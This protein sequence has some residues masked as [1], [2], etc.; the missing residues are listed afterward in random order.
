LSISSKKV[1]I[2]LGAGGHA[3]VVA[4][5]L[6]QSGKTILGLVAPDKKK[7]SKCFGLDVLGNDDEL[8]SYS[9]REVVLAN[10]IGA[11]PGI[12]LRWKLAGQ[13]REKGFQFTRVIHP[14]ATIA[15]DV[16]VGEGA[17]VMAGSIIQPGSSIA[18]DSIVNT[19]VSIDH[20][21]KIG[22]NCHLAPGVIL[23]GC[24]N[25]GKGAHLGTGAT[26]IQ[27]ISIGA[28]S[29]VSAG[30]IVYKDL[31]NDKMLIQIKQNIYK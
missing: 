6:I 13:M 19:R 22:E 2:L 17:Q 11:L 21:C 20:D 26:V 3:K 8:L 29:T 25:I 15:A 14:S 16:I 9:P 23:S 24:V 1:V 30:S 31:V 7:G 18:Q 10:G 4:E 28:N 12:V 27:N 5:A